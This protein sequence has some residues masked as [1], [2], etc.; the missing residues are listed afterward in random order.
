MRAT[1]APMTATPGREHRAD[2]VPALDASGTMRHGHGVNPIAQARDVADRCE[3]YEA[4][5]G[6]RRRPGTVCAVTVVA[7]ELELSHEQ[8]RRL[9][10]AATRVPSDLLDALVPHRPHVGLLAALGRLPEAV[11]RDVVGR[12]VSGVESLARSLARLGR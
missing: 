10:N 4:E 6:R 9:R 5:H 3:R 7:R 1:V 11:Q 12:V 2:S 8:V